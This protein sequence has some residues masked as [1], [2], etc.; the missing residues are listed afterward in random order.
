VTDP[1]RHSGFPGSFLFDRSQDMHSFSLQP[2]HRR[3]PSLI[4]VGALPSALGMAEN[5]PSCWFQLSAARILLLRPAA[6]VFGIVR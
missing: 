1:P 4:G 2:E 3:T 6:G 5:V